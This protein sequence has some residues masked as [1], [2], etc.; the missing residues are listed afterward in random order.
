MHKDVKK[1]YGS[2][3]KH[4][5]AHG[6]AHEYWSRRSFL[7]NTGLTAMGSLLA[8]NGKAINQFTPNLLTSS[9]AASDTNRVLVLIRFDGG[10]DGLN[11]IIHRGNDEYYNIR[12]TLAIPETDL[13]GL[14]D[15]YGMPNTMLPL[16]P[17]WEEG[18]MKIVHNVGYPQPNYSHFRSSDIWASASDS[19][20]HVTSGW[21]GRAMEAVFPSYI[22][23]PPTVPPAIQIGI[24]NNLIFQGVES[25]LALAIRNPTEF[26][27]IA[28]QGQLYSLNGLSDCPQGSE[29]K[30]VRQTANSAFRY[31]Q[32]IQDAYKKGITKATYE[33]N[34]LAE[35]LSIVARLIKGELGTRVYMVRIGGFDTHSDQAE[36]H[37][38]LMS[39]IANAV[40]AFYEDLDADGFGEDVLGMTFSE[41]G[42]TIFENG[43]FGTD[44]GTGTPIMLFGSQ[45]LGGGFVGS[46]PDLVN[47]GEY[48]DPDFDVD[49]RSIYGTVLKDWLGLDDRVVKH[50]L[51]DKSY[52]DG[53]VPPADIPLGFN[54]DDILLGYK[55]SKSNNLID[56]RYSLSTGGVTKL[57]LLT[58]AGYPKRELFFEFKER[59]SHSYLLN[60]TKEFVS[61]G[62]YML[63][64]ESGGKEYNRTIIVR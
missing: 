57:S 23:T 4:G 20:E 43:S 36:G 27:R 56:I 38:I 53:L 29:L 47:V 45:S 6:E 39:R 26:Y 62:T 11:T 30:Y 18:R 34:N 54:G 49:F 50:V 44:H 7:M 10:N 37:P 2:A 61:P 64:C 16:Q 48:G 35:Q 42:R 28:Q 55:A 58:L 8:L 3:I 32:T 17:F 51:G 25:S 33:D 60:P 63:R 19:G 12:P 22:E 40:S 13:W 14:S 52:I 1:R 15:E 9:L 46:A 31:S 21:I 41:F 59:G 5:K 24:D